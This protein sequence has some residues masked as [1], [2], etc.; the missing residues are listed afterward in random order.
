MVSHPKQSE[1]LLYTN[2]NQEKVLFGNTKPIKYI[3]KTI[4]ETTTMKKIDNLEFRKID[5]IETDNG[6][7]C[8]EKVC[9]LSIYEPSTEKEFD[10]LVKPNGDI[11]IGEYS[12]NVNQQFVSESLL[13][14]QSFIIEEFKKTYD[15]EISE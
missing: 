11:L 9:Y 13:K 10:F 5:W 7:K 4:K 15:L 2:Q 1:V 8:I 3:C 6:V 12:S 14:A